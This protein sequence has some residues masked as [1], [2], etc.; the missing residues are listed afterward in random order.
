MPFALTYLPRYFCKHAL[1]RKRRHIVPQILV[2]PLNRIPPLP[3]QVPCWFLP[4]CAYHLAQ[5]GGNAR[6]Q[7]R[8]SRV[9]CGR[10]RGRQCPLEEV[11]L[12]HID[13]LGFAFSGWRGSD[14]G[15]ARKGDVAVAFDALE[16]FWKLQIESVRKSVSIQVPIRAWVSLGEIHLEFGVG[17]RI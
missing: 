10:G 15:D 17:L 6:A 7:F 13:V 11:P 5:E 9:L 2:L 16:F 4:L 12:A 1:N 3:Q 8:N 14:R